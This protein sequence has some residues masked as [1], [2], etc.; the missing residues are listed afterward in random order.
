MI[1]H[2]VTSRNQHLYARQLD[3]MFRMRHEFYMLQR[4]WK[5]LT[6]SN[7]RETDEFDDENA[8]YL[9]NLD[10]FGNILSTFRLNPTTGPY[11]VA[12]KLPHY[13]SEP[14][15]R[16]EE[17]WDLGRWMVAPHARRQR[18]GE[19]ADVQKPLIVGLMEFAVDRG[20][21][22]FTALTDTAFVDRISAVWPTRPMGEP[23]GFDDAEG[24]ARLIMI[25]AGPHIL[26]ETRNKTGIYKEVMFELKPD[27]PHTTE[28][29]KLREATMQ[30]QLP[31]SRLHLDQMNTAAD[32]MLREIEH[33]T[34]VESSIQAIEEF[35]QF[36]KGMR[37]RELEDA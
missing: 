24:E 7:G 35:T 25:E 18:A 4:G 32:H 28:E 19:I 5:N 10:R 21:T 33:Q 31:L 3:E 26:A 29:K 23:H 13:L 37:E 17:I 16:S 1:I 8:V 14:A 15:P 27:L 22:G 34:D 20:I 2:V 9:M 6:S 36:I 11:L 12:D 30:D